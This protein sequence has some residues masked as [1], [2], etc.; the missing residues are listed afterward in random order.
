RRQTPEKVREAYEEILFLA[1]T[2]VLQSR[3][4]ATYPLAEHDQALTKAGEPRFGK[5]LFV[6]GKDSAGLEEPS[7]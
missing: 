1:A 4:E 2:N 7:A 5:V 3:I 6:A